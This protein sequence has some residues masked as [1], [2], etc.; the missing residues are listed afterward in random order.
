MTCAAR[1]A[2][3]EPALF[4]ASREFIARMEQK[5]Q[6]TLARMWGNE[7]GVSGRSAQSAPT[8]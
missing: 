7:G 5:I 8:A 3:A 6:L 4:N 1:A 2:Q